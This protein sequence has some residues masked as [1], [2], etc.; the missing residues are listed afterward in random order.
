MLD[1]TGYTLAD[2]RKLLEK[3]DIMIR[4]IQV[5]APPKAAAKQQ[6]ETFRVL[7][8]E[9]ME[10][11]TAVLLVCDSGRMGEQIAQQPPRPEIEYKKPL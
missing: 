4:G 10:D 5:T 11:G 2:A 8:T 6:E 7:R 3:S 1:F 9:L